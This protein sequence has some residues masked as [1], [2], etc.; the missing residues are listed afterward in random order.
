MSELQS[1]LGRLHGKLAEAEEA[2]KMLAN[3]KRELKED[4]TVKVVTMMTG[5]VNDIISIWWTGRL[6]GDRQA[7]VYGHAA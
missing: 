7:E 3:T 4:L 2:L 1:H 6:L 5:L